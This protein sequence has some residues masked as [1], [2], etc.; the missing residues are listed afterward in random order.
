M[1]SKEY[2]RQ[3][4][5][6]NELI[7][8]NEKEIENLRELAVSLPGTDYSKEKVQTSSSGDASFTNVIAKIDELERMIVDEIEQMVQL[9][10]EI[11][12]TIN[13]VRD[14]EERLLLKC[15]YLNFLTWDEICEKLNVSSRT[16]HRIHSAAL[17]S[18]SEFI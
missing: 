7:S 9:K 1:T 2:L 8:T 11:R 16:V 17:I 5:R 15:R 6:I 14:N 4:F 18:V 10:I 3:A 13:L 12:N